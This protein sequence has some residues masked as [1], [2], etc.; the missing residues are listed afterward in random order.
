[1]HIHDEAP[2]KRCH[3]VEMTPKPGCS[4]G[5]V[6]RKRT[7]ADLHVNAE[8]LRVTLSGVE[9]ASASYHTGMQVH[10]LSCLPHCFPSQRRLSP[11][12]H[13][14]SL[15]TADV[16]WSRSV[17]RGGAVMARHKGCFLRSTRSTSSCSPWRRLTNETCAS[18][19]FARCVAW[20][21]HCR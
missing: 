20:C 15:L 16:L 8:G 5:M 14:A 6:Q 18:A 7:V 10:T 2:E 1:M 17:A 3:A 11:W 19:S 12:W 4:A 21:T 13:V 9:V